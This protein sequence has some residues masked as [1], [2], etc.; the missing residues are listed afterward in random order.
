MKNAYFILGLKSVSCTDEEIR[1]AYRK[2]AAIHHPDAGGTQGAFQAVQEAY[3]LL[4]T[5]AARRAYDTAMSQRI[6]DCLSESCA[7]IVAEFFE[8]CDPRMSERTNKL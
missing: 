4:K 6:V 7:R 5:P 8:S 1:A 2:A 3:D